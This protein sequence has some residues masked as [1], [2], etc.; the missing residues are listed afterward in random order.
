VEEKGGGEV[1]NSKA[2]ERQQAEVAMGVA[3]TDAPFV[4]PP[5]DKCSEIVA[6]STREKRIKR[7]R[8][9]K[10]KRKRRRGQ[11]EIASGNLYYVQW[12]SG[13]ALG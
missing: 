12:T 6:G 1:A 4:D 11:R 5:S 13:K 8:N 7:K 2:V 3:G 10:R 9:S